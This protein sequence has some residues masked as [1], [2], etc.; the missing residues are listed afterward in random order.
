MVDRDDIIRMAREAG[1]KPFRS[2]EHWDDVQVFA[3]P[4]VLER[5][6]ALV[7]A[8]E[9][10]SVAASS[11]RDLTCVCGAVWDGEQMVHAP[12]KREWVGLTDEEI[13]DLGYLSEKFDASNSEWFDRWGFARAIEAK[14]KE[15]NKW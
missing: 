9:R 5:F 15:K 4:N 12:P 2:P 1:C 10:E 13:Q 8:A 11:K 6:A 14:L 3:T 7:A